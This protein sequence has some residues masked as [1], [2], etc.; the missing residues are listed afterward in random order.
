MSEQKEGSSFQSENIPKITLEKYM[1]RIKKF[2]IINENYYFITALIYL[3][4]IVAK[5]QSNIQLTPFTVHRLLFVAVLT[6]IKFSNDNNYQNVYYAKVG[7]IKLQDLNK[8]EVE[9]LDLIEYNL[10]VSEEEYNQE[11]NKLNL[12]SENL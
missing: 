6:A 11:Q 5:N 8:M 4:R 3:E 1:E 2:A 10:L 12:F 9:F 7:G